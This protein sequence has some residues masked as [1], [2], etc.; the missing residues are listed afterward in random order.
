MGAL[1]QITEFSLKFCVFRYIVISESLKVQSFK[2]IS[3]T[4]KYNVALDIIV[5]YGI[6][7]FRLNFIKDLNILEWQLCLV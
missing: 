5:P 4:Y 1:F 6:S 2:L 3:S 7:G